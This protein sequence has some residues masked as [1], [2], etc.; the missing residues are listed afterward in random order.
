[1][2]AE[3]AARML[4]VSS[5]KVYALAAPAGPIPCQRIGRTVR[6]TLADIQ[7]YQAQ[8]R[9]TAI[10]SEVA[11][12]LS[13]AGV[14]TGDGS[15]LESYFRRRG[16]AP[17]LTPTTGSSRPAAAIYSTRDVENIVARILSGDIPPNPRAKK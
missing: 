16:R 14:S 6:F 10:R 1:M 13:S 4:G 15:E 3:E 7:E 9:C 11:G 12:S 17:R 8:C 2:T 5:R